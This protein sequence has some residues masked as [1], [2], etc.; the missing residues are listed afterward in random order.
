M[1]KLSLR[2]ELEHFLGYWLDDDFA[3]RELR[4]IRSDI[5]RPLPVRVRARALEAR[6]EVERAAA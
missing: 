3:L 5:E 6:L 4:F 1:N 2:A